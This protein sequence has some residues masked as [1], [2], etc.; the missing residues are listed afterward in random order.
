MSRKLLMILWLISTLV[1]SSSVW[2]EDVLTLLEEGIYAEETKGDLDEAMTIYQKIIDE[3]AG[4]SAN[5]AEAY[6]R[7][8]TCYLKTG[9]DTKA[10]E[11]FKELL[12]GYR[13]HEEIASDARAQL[14][15]LN[16][17]DEEDQTI[18]PLELGP[19]PWEAGETC[20]YNFG[21]PVIENLG[22][23]ILSIKDVTINGNDLWRMEDYVIIPGEGQS[24][25]YRIDVLKKDFKPFS[26]ILKGILSSKVK[27]G[28][29]HIQ[30]D[31]DSL[32]TKDTREIPINTFVY[33]SNQVEYLIRLLPLNESY[34]T[35]LSIFN[36]AIGNIMKVEVRT[37]GIETVK[38][39]AGTF[40]CYCVE[41][42]MDSVKVK[43]WIST[44]DKRYLV[45]YDVGAQAVMELEKIEQVSKDEP[46]VFNDSESGI[47]MSAPE[48]WHFMRSAITASD[49]LLVNIQSP[50][51]NA[52]SYFFIYPHSGAYKTPQDYPK[53]T[54][55]ILKQHFKNYTPRPESWVYGEIDGLPSSTYISDYD[56]EDKKMVE[57]RTDILNKQVGY[58]FII[59]LEKEAFDEKI[60]TDFESIAQSFKW[61][62][63][64]DNPA[65]TVLKHYKSPDYNFE[66]DIPERW[67]TSPP[68]YNNSPTE[69]IRFGSQQGGSHILIV[70]RNPRYFNQTLEE[71][72][73]QTQNILANGG[74]GN[75]VT[76][77]TTI[78]SN[79]V[80]TLDF[81]KP[82]ENGGIWSC[83]HYFILDGNFTYVLGFGTSNKDGMIDLYDRVAKTFRT[84]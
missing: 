32:G 27:Y 9:D 44:D 36:P 77:E 54:M 50:E 39:P 76:A 68:N 4:D 16:A 55:G 35:S 59:R 19:V 10:I 51:I 3:N 80:I 63:T 7:L 71:I 22:K 67:Y 74:F 12:T 73:D 20:W 45:K 58:V 83:R 64:Y 33:D 24:Q 41:L 72:C 79:D 82:M 5:I 81:D 15:K 31:I 30:L 23:M 62:K 49:K 61:N 2:G 46:E 57:Y 84:E 6:Y 29:D 14:V 52:S 18:T 28:K 26:S 8:G 37:T 38:V 42:V 48:G 34:G 60:K 25:F 43:Q 1:F 47:S 70:F 75:F 21:T 53:A 56:K 66:L 78:G 40:E 11:M 17:L 65:T 69:V 13:E